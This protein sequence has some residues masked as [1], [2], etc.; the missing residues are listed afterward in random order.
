[1]KPIVAIVGR[2]NVGKST[3]FNRIIQRRL[4][5]V[6]S[7]PG[8]TRDRIYADSE[9]AGRLFT[10]VDTGGIEMGEGDEFTAQIRK[11]AEL[12]IEGANVIIFVVDGRQGLTTTDQ[13]VAQILR[14]TEK[15][16]V[17]AVNKME[18]WD[19]NTHAYE[20]YSLSLGKPLPISAE[21]GTNIGDLLDEVIAFFPAEIDSE[22]EDEMVKVA[23]IGRPNVGKSS[24]INSILGEERVIVTDIP[25]TT[26][27]AIDI[28]V[29]REG[30]KIN[31]I[32]TA[33]LR[34]RS[35]IDLAVERYSVMRTLR[36]IDRSDVVLMLI[37][38]TEGVAEQDQKIV[39]YAHEAGKA[40]ILVV[41]KWDL[42]EKDSKTAE[43]FTQSIRKE[44][45]FLSYAP[46]VFVSALTGQRVG[47][48]LEMIHA[49]AS[50]YY[51]RLATSVINTVI[52]EAV[53]INPPPTDKGNRLKVFYV[54]QP[55]VKPPT[56]VFFVNDPEL[57][58]FSY[59]RYLENKLREAFGFEGTPLRLVIRAR[60]QD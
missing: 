26:R 41:N 36:A 9:W 50:Q 19:M 37:N 53:A 55:S 58:H 57:M 4:A 49:V 12:A 43:H 28:V 51:L 17:L 35:R 7:E 38:A 33:G 52:R 60:E 29:E 59:K 40:V 39:G 31:F 8:I 16:V 13:D 45:A 6:E 14:R 20:F 5:I 48:V 3:L 23:V 15:P 56:F 2:P 25:G 18:N 24:L 21:H 1:M 11:Q 47:R 54:T 30:K 42:V 46:I 22:T 27:D 10:L 32:D 34:R 44:L